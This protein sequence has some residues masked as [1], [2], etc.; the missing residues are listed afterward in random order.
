LRVRDVVFSSQ[1]QLRPILISSVF[2]TLAF[3]HNTG[4]KL[5]HPYREGSRDHFHIVFAV[6]FNPASFQLE[7]GGRHH[8]GMGCGGK[9]C[10]VDCIKGKDAEGMDKQDTK[11]PNQLEDE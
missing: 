11:L 2:G 8:D 3:L 9:T 6:G 7:I 4:L 1:S 10:R 5:L